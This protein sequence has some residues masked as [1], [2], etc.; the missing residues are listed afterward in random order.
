M[1]DWRTVG[2]EL[3]AEYKQG[4]DW[5]AAEISRLRESSPEM[6]FEQAIFRCKR[7]D[8][9]TLLGWLRSGKPLSSEARESL[10]G[11]IEDLLTPE[12]KRRGRPSN[13]DEQDAALCALMYYR[14][15]RERNA[16]LGVSD[17]GHSPQ[18]KEE[19]VRVVLHVH[20]E[21]QGLDP[22]RVRERL[23]QVA[24]DFPKMP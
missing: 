18:M 8:P 4:H 3:A 2:A 14:R 13:K 1:M 17:Y 7:G 11:F 16:D 21:Y 24:K 12:P 19:A 15:W 22:W 10:A 20:T 5:V 23:E 6:Q 9:A